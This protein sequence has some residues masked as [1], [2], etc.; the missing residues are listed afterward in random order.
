MVVYYI[1]FNPLRF[2]CSALYYMFCF[3]IELLCN[4]RFGKQE[5]SHHSKWGQ[6]PVCSAS[7]HQ[8]KEAEQAFGFASQVCHEKGLLQDGQGGQEPGK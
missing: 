7:N 2:S 3:L 6:R 4:F 1:V 8:D 5:N